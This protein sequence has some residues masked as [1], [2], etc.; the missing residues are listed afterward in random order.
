MATAG[1]AEDYT[2]PQA[3]EMPKFAVV[4]GLKNNC[5]PP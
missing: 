4:Q 2:S 3:M 1:M 5:K